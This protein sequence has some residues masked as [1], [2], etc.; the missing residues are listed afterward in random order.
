M[1]KK[2]LWQK[3]KYYP[4][5]ANPADGIIEYDMVSLPGWAA[6][7]FFFAGVVTDDLPILH[8]GKTY[9]PLDKRAQLWRSQDELYRNIMNIKT[10]KGYALA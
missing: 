9:H 10:V 7:H 2:M 1:L 4:P 6:T 8:K 3:K 5:R